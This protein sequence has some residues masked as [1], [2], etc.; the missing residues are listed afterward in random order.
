M[1]DA[2]VTFKYGQKSWRVVCLCVF[3]NDHL[4]AKLDIYDTYSV[5]E[6][7][8]SET[9]ATPRWPLTKPNDDHYLDSHCFM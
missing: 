6:N 7:H 5:Q 8:N 3:S 1:F 4:Y 2:T 9:S